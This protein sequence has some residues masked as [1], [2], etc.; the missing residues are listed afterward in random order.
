MFYA[1]L[2][3]DL[4][5]ITTIVMNKSCLAELPI[6]CYLS[7]SKTYYIL[8]QLIYVFV[9]YSLD[10][11]II[12]ISYTLNILYHTILYNIYLV[13]TYFTLHKT[14]KRMYQTEKI[15]NKKL[16]K[17]IPVVSIVSCCYLKYGATLI[18]FPLPIVPYYGS[19]VFHMYL[20]P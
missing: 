13:Y 2:Y 11:H 20:L 10:K 3:N 6:T 4:Y 8:Y 5:F 17:L 1:C 16:T 14:I 7:I 12:F 19:F 9:I 18:I 15:N